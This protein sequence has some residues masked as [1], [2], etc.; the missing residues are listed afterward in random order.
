[1]HRQERANMTHHIRKPV[2]CHIKGEHHQFDDAGTCWQCGVTRGQ[3]E[4]LERLGL[5]PGLRARYPE[6]VSAND[7]GSVGWAALTLLAVAVACV[8]AWI[9][10]R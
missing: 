5:L 1:M 3:V 10:T 2:P 8:L 9:V 6:G 7:G 4:R